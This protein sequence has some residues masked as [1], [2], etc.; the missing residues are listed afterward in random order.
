MIRR[1]IDKLLGG[2]CDRQ[3]DELTALRREVHALRARVAE[4]ESEAATPGAPVTVGSFAQAA[5][6]MA[7]GRAVQLSEAEAPV[8]G[9]SAVAEAAAPPQ[10]ERELVVEL[11]DCIACGTCLEYC[12]SAFELGADG[13]ARVVPHSAPEVEVQAA[14]DAC[15]TQ[16]I[17][18]RD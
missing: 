11:E 16:C 12:P 9:P 6:A 14:I 3:Q 15:P 1:A 8:P 5:R 17:H 7:A 18:W 2:G 4:L 10:A 13:R